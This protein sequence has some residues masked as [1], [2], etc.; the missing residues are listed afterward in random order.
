MAVYGKLQRPFRIFRAMNQ[1]LEDSAEEYNVLFI[2]ISRLMKL[3]NKAN[4]RF[5]IETQEVSY[6][7]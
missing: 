5:I 4:Q 3:P 6:S 1:A 2:V 7:F